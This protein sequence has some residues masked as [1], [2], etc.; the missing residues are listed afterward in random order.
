MGTIHKHTSSFYLTSPTSASIQIWDLILP[1]AL[2]RYL[3]LPNLYF[4]KMKAVLFGAPKIGVAASLALCSI[5]RW[6]YQMRGTYSKIEALTGTV[7]ASVKI[8][9]CQLLVSNPPLTIAVVPNIPSKV[10]IQNCLMRRRTIP[11]IVVK[12]NCGLAMF[13][14]YL[15]ILDRS[16]WG[17]SVSPI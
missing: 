5:V 9:S 16:N 7:S 1:T 15:N 13:F 12:S 6:K 4:I 11:H 8:S 2:P 14:L 3:S 17:N 10:S